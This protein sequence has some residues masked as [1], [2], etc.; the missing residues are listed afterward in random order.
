MQEAKQI[1]EAKSVQQTQP[2]Y[3]DID[4]GH[5]V[6]KA[7]K[8]KGKE[9]KD[10]K[11]AIL[12]NDV[13]KATEDILIRRCLED[14]ST[15][16]SSAELKYVLIQIRKQSLGTV[17]DFEYVCECSY[18]NKLKITLDEV[19]VLEYEPWKKIEVNS[20]TYDFQ[21]I[22]N[23]KYYNKNQDVLDDIKE[24]AF[25]TKS[26]NDNESMSFQEVQDFY[27]ELDIDEFDEV[28]DEFSKMYC[29]IKDVHEVQCKECKLKKKFEFDEIPGFIPDSWIK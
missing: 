2:N 7:R 27:D 12:N 25:Y 17:F 15:S 21:N 22:Q 10:F 4:L 6:I 28:F 1:P 13:E 5:R 23:A 8:W 3:F 14:P 20:I 26:I 24:I 18:K 9:R 29:S 16:L 19:S 11:K